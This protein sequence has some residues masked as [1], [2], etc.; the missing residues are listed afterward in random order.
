MKRRRRDGFASLKALHDLV[1]W[2]DR[3]DHGL[4]QQRKAPEMK[5][6]LMKRFLR[7]RIKDLVFLAYEPQWRF[8]HCDGSTKRD[9]V[10]GET[11]SKASFFQVHL[12][13]Q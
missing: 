13:N 2:K 1:I 4:L 9:P 8:V 6:R 7:K 12:E 3:D 11:E 10:D 5:K